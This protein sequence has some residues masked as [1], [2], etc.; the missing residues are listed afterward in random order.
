MQMAIM[1][2]SIIRIALYEAYNGG[3][4]LG[5][6]KEE[7]SPKDNFLFSH[8]SKVTSPSHVARQCGRTLVH[9]S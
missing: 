7:A 2:K 8:R 6:K 3:F 5:V 9:R 1:H 4:E